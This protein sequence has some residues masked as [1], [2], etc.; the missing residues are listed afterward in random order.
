MSHYLLSAGSVTIQHDKKK[1]TSQNHHIPEKHFL[2]SPE[3]A[4]K[5]QCNHHIKK[6][7]NLKVNNVAKTKQM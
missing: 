3:N 5:K 1:K 7:T 2:K 6:P 4:F